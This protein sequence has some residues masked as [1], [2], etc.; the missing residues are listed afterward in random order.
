[1]RVCVDHFVFRVCY[2]KA[3]LKAYQA[4]SD[5]VDALREENTK[6]LVM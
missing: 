1:M 6:A 5:E 3:A 2:I 4:K